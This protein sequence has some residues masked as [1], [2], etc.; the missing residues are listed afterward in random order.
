MD[1]KGRRAVEGSGER[2][3]PLEGDGVGV[4]LR[5]SVE[6]SCY[7]WRLGVSLTSPST[8]NVRYR[9]GA[10]REIL[11][12]FVENGGGPGISAFQ[13]A[14]YGREQKKYIYIEMI[15]MF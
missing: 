12:E 7:Y 8:G 11:V 14:T 4:H 6:R 3:G 1:E 5:L 15:P 13:D 10:W 2:K 9:A